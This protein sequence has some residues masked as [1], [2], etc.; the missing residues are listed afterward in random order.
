[1]KKILIT[2]F[3]FILSNIQAQKDTLNLN[4]QVDKNPIIYGSFD[5]LFGKT[6]TIGGSL[7]YQHQ[8]HLLTF[9][10][11]KHF[12]LKP[13]S[14]ILF[15][16]LNFPEKEISDFGLLYGKRWIFNNHAL[17]IS[18]G[19]SYNDN[20]IFKKGW[21]N[22][23][24]EQEFN[25]IGF[26]FELSIHWFKSKKEPFRVLYGLVPVGEPTVISRNF[27]FKIAGNISKE[28]YVGFGFTVGIGAHKVY[29]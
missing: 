26:P 16:I 25:S 17:A 9:R 2:L 22:N 18:G 10:I 15:P 11:M 12:H 8:K 1:M 5:L 6:F 7:N 21:F 3:V 28:S 19:L 20:V 24:I 4:L 29:D 27:G 14:F 23:A 13:T